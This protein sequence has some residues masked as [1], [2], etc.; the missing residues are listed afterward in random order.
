MISIILETFPFP[1]SILYYI[2]SLWE[3][4]ILR[5]LIIQRFDAFGNV[6]L[7][8]ITT[9]SFRIRNAYSLPAFRPAYSAQKG[10]GEIARS[11]F[12][13]YLA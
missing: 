7:F 12:S 10:A 6:F 8:K 4:K 5:F 1:L 3:E 2:F 11:R 9:L 13:Y